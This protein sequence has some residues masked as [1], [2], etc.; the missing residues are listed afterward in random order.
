M[1]ANILVVDRNEAFATMLREML[2]NEGGYQVQT[3]RG[4]SEALAYLWKNDCDLTIIDM[5]LDPSDLSYKELVPRIR[6]IR[7][8]MRLMLIPLQG[9]N[10]PADARRFEIQGT[11]SKPFFADDLLPKIRRALATGDRPSPTVPV[12]PPRPPASVR[13]APVQ[14]TAVRAPIVKGTETPP[15]IQ[16]L[17]FDLAVETQAV[18]VL[19]VTYSQSATKVRGQVGTLSDAQVKTLARL[20]VTTVQAARSAA[21]LLGQADAPFEHNMF[22][23]DA[24]RLYIMALS[25]TALLIVVTPGSTPLGTIRYGV[26]R[27]ARDLA[28]ATLT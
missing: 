26:R 3:V 20:S 16:Q 15:G 14:D 9:E 22:E 8:A 7:S 27:A 21:R 6:Q 12:T 28:A 1:G 2:E 5:D 17:L 18:A 23:S 13:A 24:L 25:A 4:G 11:L 19:L 10:L